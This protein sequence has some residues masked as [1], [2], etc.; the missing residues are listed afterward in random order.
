[1][2]DGGPV[3]GEECR[4][5][6]SSLHGDYTGINERPFFG[7]VNREAGSCHKRPCLKKPIAKEDTERRPNKIPGH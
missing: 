6:R 4:A 7:S 1:M 2:K 5:G 3:Y